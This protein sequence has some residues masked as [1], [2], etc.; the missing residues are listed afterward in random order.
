MLWAWL[1]FQLPVYNEG[2][3][4]VDVVVEKVVDVEKLVIK[5]S[6]VEHFV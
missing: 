3:V 6:T 5:A 1:T 4:D 2:G